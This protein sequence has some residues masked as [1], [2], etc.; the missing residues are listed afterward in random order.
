M[1]YCNLLIHSGIAQDSW[2]EIDG[3]E[4]LMAKNYNSIQIFNNI[5]LYGYFST[6]SA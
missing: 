3:I 6:D 5:K 1:N 4:T 2:T